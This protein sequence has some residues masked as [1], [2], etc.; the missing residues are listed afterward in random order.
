MFSTS[1]IDGLTNWLT[2]DG[3]PNVA[4]YERRKQKTGGKAVKPFP[5]FCVSVFCFILPGRHTAAVTDKKA[6]ER[7]CGAVSQRIRNKAQ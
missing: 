4:Q 3:C 1:I 6:A 7:R 2:D 5:P